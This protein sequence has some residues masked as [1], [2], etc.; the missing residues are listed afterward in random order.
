M[1]F[2][3]FSIVLHIVIFIFGFSLDSNKNFQVE[4]IGNNFS[5]PSI[6]VNFSSVQ[7]STTPQLEESPVDS[8]EEII[9][10]KVEKEVPK[11]KL[12]EKKIEVIK[13]ETPKVSKP[14]KNL[15]KK[16]TESVTKNEKPQTPSMPKNN[17]DL[18]QLS[19]G[20]FAAKNQGVKGL[21][22]SFISQPD[23]E[24]P[25]VAKRLSYSKEVSIKVRFLV[26]FKGEVEEIKFYNEK[27]SLGFQEEV[28]KTLKN[29]KLTPVTLN[30]KPI[31]LYF[32][33]EFKFNQK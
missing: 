18:I 27:D 6:S 32:Y 25:L 7:A 8:T 22:Y 11:P 17:S 20:V 21:N 15:Q 1:N 5:S 9:E 13:K 2:F 19:N 4:N 28:E 23:P 10:E 30:N 16:K 26:G 29:W 3:I 12:E 31:K 33:K 24:Y 14:K